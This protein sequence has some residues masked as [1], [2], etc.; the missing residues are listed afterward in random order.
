M[1]HD[2][3]ISDIYIIVAEE[4]VPPLNEIDDHPS[5]LDSINDLV[6]ELSSGIDIDFRPNEN[7][8]A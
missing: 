7:L 3:I 6:A 1:K 8:V 5:F 4:Y 2:F